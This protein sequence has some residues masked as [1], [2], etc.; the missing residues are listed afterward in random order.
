VA[1]GQGSTKVT[2]S[3]KHPDAA[4]SLNISHTSG[5]PCVGIAGVSGRIGAGKHGRAVPDQRRSVDIRELIREMSIANP[6][7]G[8]TT[9]SRRT[10]QARD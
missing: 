5:T 2:M 1:V 6:P 3:V 10:A 7:V 4:Q 9:D 8:C